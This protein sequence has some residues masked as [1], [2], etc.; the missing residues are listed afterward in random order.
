MI[1]GEL[2]ITPS[3]GP[4]PKYKGDEA[5]ANNPQIS[6]ASSTHSNRIYQFNIN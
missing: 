3:K 2:L 1:L 4:R 5:N 6:L